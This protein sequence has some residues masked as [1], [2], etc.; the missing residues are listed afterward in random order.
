MYVT[1]VDGCGGDDDCD[2]KKRAVVVV[3][4]R[5]RINREVGSV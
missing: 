5:G 4:A 1:T 3:V 2:G